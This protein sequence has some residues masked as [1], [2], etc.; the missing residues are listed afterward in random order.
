MNQKATISVDMRCH[1]VRTIHKRIDRRHRPIFLLHCFLHCILHL[2]GSICSGICRSF[3]KSHCFFS[4]FKTLIYC[5]RKAVHHRF[6]FCP[7][8]VHSRFS[9]FFYCIIFSWHL[10]LSLAF[11]FLLL[12]CFYKNTSTLIPMTQFII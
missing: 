9:S 2:W 11:H 6:T 7:A 4:C 5:S 3:G 12:H 10:F 8:L 1:I